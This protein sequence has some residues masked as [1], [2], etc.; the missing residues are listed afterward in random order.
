MA[1][2]QT[3]GWFQPATKLQADLLA[4]KLFCLG[5]LILL[6]LITAGVL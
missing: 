4:L 2:P 5:S 1:V 6:G 3:S